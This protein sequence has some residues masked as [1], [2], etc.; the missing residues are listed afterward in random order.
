VIDPERVL[1][2]RSATDLIVIIRVLHLRAL[3]SLR[4]T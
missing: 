4:L 3:L 1:Q 2:G